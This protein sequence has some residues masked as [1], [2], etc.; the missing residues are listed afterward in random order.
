MT[1]FRSD[2]LNELQWRG[3]IHQAS[4][5]EGIDSLAARGALVAYVGYD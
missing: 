4:D 1:A 5:A 2:F 3:F